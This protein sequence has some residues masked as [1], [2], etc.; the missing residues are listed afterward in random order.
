MA[1]AEIQILISA[2]DNMTATMKKIEGQLESSN[3]NIQ[4]QTDVTSQTFD[5][6][7][8]SLLVL[9]QMAS[10]VD[11]IFISYMNVQ[12]RLEN[13]TER[14]MNAQDRL[15]DAQ[16]N[17]NKVMNDSKSSA[18]DVAKAQTQVERASRSL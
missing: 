17:L 11:S 1:D 3:R 14:V 18:E 9:G 6:Q 8:G 15:T 7:M 13:A 5:K 4:K 12:I 16:D 10:R 2:V